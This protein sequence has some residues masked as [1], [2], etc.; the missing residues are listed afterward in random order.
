MLFAQST[1]NHAGVAL[2]GDIKDFEHLYQAL[3]NV[4]GEEGEFVDLHSAR[5]RILA[6]CY[7]LRHALMGDREY[8]FVENGLDRDMKKRMK[9]L[10][11]DQNLYLK[12]TVLWPEMLFILLTLNDFVERYA[13]KLEKTKY[14][15][16]LYKKPKVIWDGT[17]AQVRMFQAAIADCLKQTVSEAAYARILNKFNDRWTSTNHYIT[18]YIDVLNDKFINMSKEKRLKH[19]SVFAKRIAEQDRE[20]LELEQYLNEEAKLRNCRVDELRLNIEYPEEIDW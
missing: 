17:I 15:Y 20:Y 14:T 13:Q 1:P 3:H 7:D 8:V 9:V 11:S 2:F 10:A 19:I 5:I 16:E 4:V 6:I 12:I 18:Q